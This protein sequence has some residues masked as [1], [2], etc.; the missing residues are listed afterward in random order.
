[1]SDHCRFAGLDDGG[2]D[3]ENIAGPP[4]FSDSGE[5]STVT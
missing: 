1:M 4:G 3:Q 2:G 5:H